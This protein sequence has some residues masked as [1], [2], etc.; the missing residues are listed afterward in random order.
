MNT[1][2]DITRR[3]HEAIM[4]RDDDGVRGLLAENA[5]WDG[6]TGL[7]EAGHLRG[8]DAIVSQAVAGLRRQ[9]LT[10]RIVTSRYVDAGDAVIVFGHY[11]GISLRSRAFMKAEF[12]HVV[13]VRDGVITSF[14]EHVD[15]LRVAEALSRHDDRPARQRRHIVRLPA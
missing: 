5:E 6:T 2:T 13:T 15:T 1:S 10:W 14:V 9:W 11:E 3:L 12:V 8:R 7:P 4:L